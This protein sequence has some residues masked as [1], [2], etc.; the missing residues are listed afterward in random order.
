MRSRS[1][2]R[3]SVGT[4]PGLPDSAFEH[5]GQ[6]TKREVRAA[7]LAALQPFPGAL[8][9][10]IGAGCGSIS[11]EFMRAARGARALAIEDMPARRAMIEANAARLGVPELTLVKGRAPAALKGLETPDAVFIGGGLTRPG[12]FDTAFAA[13]RIGGILVANSVTVEGE[14]ML[15]ALAPRHGG[16]LT[17]ISVSRAE[18]V[19]SFLAFK[20]ML[21]V[22]QLIIRKAAAK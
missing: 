3:L 11:I 9:W 7:T 15:L 6:L 13:L 21:Q 20:P 14:A 18:P 8:L 12:V 1:R 17:R 10:D 5:D 2:T 4:G 22:T 19:G 16:T